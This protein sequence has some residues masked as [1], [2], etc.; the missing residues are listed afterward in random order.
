[1][2]DKSKVSLNS[3]YNSLEHLS[4]TEFVDAAKHTNHLNE[5]EFYIML[6]SFELKKRQRKL[7]PKKGGPF[8]NV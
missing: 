4:L 3:F 6:L 7:L 1:M 8:Y 2:S 5:R